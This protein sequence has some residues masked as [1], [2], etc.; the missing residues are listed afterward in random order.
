MARVDTVWA[1]LAS[2]SAVGTGAGTAR[3]PGSVILLGCTHGSACPLPPMACADSQLGAPGDA[4]ASVPDSSFCLR[5]RLCAQGLAV[6][7]IFRM[8]R[9][10]PHG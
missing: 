5:V 7:F 2:G 9:L 10:P 4:Q 3:E 1:I 6:P 8:L